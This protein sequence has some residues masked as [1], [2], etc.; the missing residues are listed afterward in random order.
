MRALAQNPNTSI[1]RTRSVRSAA[2]AGGT[3]KADGRADDRHSV[4]SPPIRWEKL[5]NGGE[6]GQCGWLTD[7]FGASWQVVPVALYRMLEDED[8]AKPQRVMK[9]MLSMN[10]LDVAAL[11]R[12]YINM[13]SS[14]KESIDGKEIVKG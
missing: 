1:L 6:N 8:E 5:S 2:G 13:D 14:K 11:E 7:R 3:A 9:A 12:A 10:K 4:T